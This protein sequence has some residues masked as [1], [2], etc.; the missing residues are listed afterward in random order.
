MVTSL[1]DIQRQAM[2]AEVPL[3]RLGRPAEIAELG[4]WL[5]LHRHLP[6]MCHP[7]DLHQLRW[8]L[9]DALSHPT[10]TAGPVRARFATADGGGWQTLT[11]GG[12]GVRL[13]NVDDPHHVLCRVKLAQS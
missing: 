11:I 9:K 4:L 8:F 6:T 3:G 12:A 2:V 13:S 10:A 1:T 5:P 7:D